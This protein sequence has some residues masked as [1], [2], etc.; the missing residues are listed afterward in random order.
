MHVLLA[1]ATA[2]EIKA[3]LEEWPGPGPAGAAENH[4]L[5]HIHLSSLITGVGLVSAT[6]Q[7]CKEITTSRPDLVIQAGVAGCF[8]TSRPLGEVVIVNEEV[9]ADQG[10][11]ENG[12][13]RDLFDLSLLQQD[14]EP[15]C[16]GV[17]LNP[18]L[19]C[20]E[21]GLPHPDNAAREKISRLNLEG[22][23]KVR[24]V[25]VNEIT[26][27][28]DRIA[29]LKQRYNPT[30][31]SMEG[32]ALH[33]VCLRENIPFLQ[34]RSYSNYVGERDKSQWDLGLAI[35]NLNETLIRILSTQKQTV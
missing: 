20:Q 6:Y 2:F 11:E 22:L 24:G 30:T 18:F 19:G 14:R 10:V 12:T 8:D 21:P 15:Y 27:R 4:P 34:L 28:A 7:L 9:I 17:L 31:E 35:A 23:K 3:I 33:Y 1:A 5:H 13:F 25:S 26:T 16:R 29:H 32:A